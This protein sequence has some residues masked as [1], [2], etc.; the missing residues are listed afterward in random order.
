M[1][2]FLILLSILLSLA[3]LCNYFLSHSILGSKWRIFVVPG[4]IFHE[5]CH[6][7]ACKLTGAKIIKI[8]FF[9]KEGGSVTHNKPIVPILGPILISTAPLIL[10][11][12]VFYFLASRIHLESNLDFP[13]LYANYKSL[14][15]LITFS[16]S[17]ITIFYLLISIAVTM[18]PS[19]KDLLNMLLP[20]IILVGVFYLIFRYTAFDS[21]RFDFVLSKLSLVLN[22]AIFILIAFTIISFLLFLITKFVLK[23]GF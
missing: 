19:R 12:L 9:D 17:N 21:S 20:L 3:Y 14:N 18:T 15:H 16:W 5:L 2:Y 6:A 10:G 7:L 8:S 13:S 1:I 23:R 4:V 22:M 11:I